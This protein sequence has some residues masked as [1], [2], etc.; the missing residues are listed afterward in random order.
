MR[1]ECPCPVS[2]QLRKRIDDLIVAKRTPT[3][4]WVSKS[5]WVELRSEGSLRRRFVNYP[6]G[7]FVWEFE[8]LPIEIEDEKKGT[9]KGAE[10]S[11]GKP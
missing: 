11:Q 1:I 2:D 4:I 7:N 6:P 5:E 8:G 9:P 3:K 10:G